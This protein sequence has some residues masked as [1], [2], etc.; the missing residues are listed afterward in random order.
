MQTTRTHTT[1]VTG[2][3]TG[4]GLEAARQL[5]ALSHAVV[6]TGRSQR[7][8]NAAR[9]RLVEGGADPQRID[10]VVVDLADGESVIRAADELKRRGQV[11]D[12]LLFNAGAIPPKDTRATFKGPHA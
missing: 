3:S 8:V 6:L 2:G 11:F 7:S 12:A 5:L 4:L 1:L 9:A 10:T